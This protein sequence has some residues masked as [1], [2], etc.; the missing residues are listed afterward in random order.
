MDRYDGYSYVYGFSPSVLIA[1][2]PSFADQPQSVDAS[3]NESAEFSCTA[4]GYPPPIIEWRRVTSLSNLSILHDVNTE[5]NTDIYNSTGTINITSTLVIEPVQYDDFGYYLCVAMFSSNNL[6][7]RVISSTA[8]LTSK[9]S[10]YI[11]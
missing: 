8:I 6:E 3:V 10:L 5:L 2:A 7:S 1:F 11:Y 4:F 9:L